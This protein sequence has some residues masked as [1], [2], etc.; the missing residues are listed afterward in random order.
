MRTVK[1]KL[2]GVF[3]W[4]LLAGLVFCLIA[5]SAYANEGIAPYVGFKTELTAGQSVIF[6]MKDHKG[7][8]A[9]FKK[10]KG[11]GK[12]LATIQFYG[13]RAN[14]NSDY[15]LLATKSADARGVGFDTQL[16]W[17]RPSAGCVSN[18]CPKIKYTCTKNRVTIEVRTVT[19]K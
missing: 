19:A 4:A 9:V 1:K 3:G 14:N 2:H 5:P 15:E 8:N 10:I 11:S 13:T 16:H 12:G 17:A 6:N 18:I 7:I